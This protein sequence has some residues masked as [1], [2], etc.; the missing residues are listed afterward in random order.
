MPKDTTNAL[1]A[2][3]AKGERDANGVRTLAE[4]A[5]KAVVVDQHGSFIGKLTR[6][7]RSVL[8]YGCTTCDP[9][10]AGTCVDCVAL[11]E[12]GLGPE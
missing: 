8:L 9:T 2:K 4:P 11:R 3:M 10:T 12:K 7:Q 1:K 6:S 5:P